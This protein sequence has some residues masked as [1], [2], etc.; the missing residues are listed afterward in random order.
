MKY[1]IEIHEILSRKVIINADNETD[2]F[3]KA[4][5]LYEDG[6]IVIDDRNYSDMVINNCG[7]ATDEDL[8]NYK[9]E[10]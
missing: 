4:E 3:D 7:E 9:E 5:E 2:A 1:V 10:Y 8:E 6:T